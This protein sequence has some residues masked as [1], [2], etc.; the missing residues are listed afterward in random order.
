M[1]TPLETP[2]SEEILVDDVVDIHI[3]EAVFRCT[4]LSRQRFE[5]AERLVEV[6]RLAIPV[7]E[8]PD[9]IQKFVLALTQA[10]KV[11]VR[12]PLS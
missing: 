8:L 6:K 4:L 7:S 1:V 12:S 3:L 10:A 2:T 11:I 5:G 9:I